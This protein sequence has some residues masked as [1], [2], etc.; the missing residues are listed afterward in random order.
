M[1]AKVT[2]FYIKEQD[3]KGTPRLVLW[4]LSECANEEGHCFPS[5]ATIAN[6]CNKS[7]RSIQRA[8]NTLESDGKIGR[9]IHDGKHTKYGRTNGYY[10]NDYRVSI[11]LD[12]TVTFV[13]S[14]MSSVGIS[15]T[16]KVSVLATR[17]DVNVT[18]T[19]TNTNQNNL[20]NTTNTTEIARLKKQI[21]LLERELKIKNRELEIK[22][23]G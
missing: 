3:T 12:P 10:L 13:T 7:E 16:S 1:S 19:N 23:E 15:N 2:N 14:K 21:T 11:G 20:T 6:R 5:V 9:K 4:I 8:L 18:Q 17:D 22:N